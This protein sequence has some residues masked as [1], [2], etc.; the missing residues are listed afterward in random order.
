MSIWSASFHTGLS[1]QTDELEASAT[2]PISVPAYCGLGFRALAPLSTKQTASDT[3]S[4]C[5]ARLTMEFRVPESSVTGFGQ[6]PVPVFVSLYSLDA[7][8]IEAVAVL[9]HPWVL[10]DSGMLAETRSRL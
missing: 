5:L 6:R 10:Y 7:S 9:H 2:G 3:H 4:P 1:G 8:N